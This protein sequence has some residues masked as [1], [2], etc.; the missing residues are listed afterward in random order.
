MLSTFHRLLSRPGEKGVD[1]HTT[2]RAYVC[3]PFLWRGSTA[4]T[5]TGVCRGARYAAAMTKEETNGN[6]IILVRPDSPIDG[7][8]VLVSSSNSGRGVAAIFG[9]RLRWDYYIWCLMVDVCWW[10]TT[11]PGERFGVHMVAFHSREGRESGRGSKLSFLES[12]SR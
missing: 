3:V 8:R 2:T 5:A 10:A 7:A 4:A 1:A 12:H 9:L 6:T 11:R